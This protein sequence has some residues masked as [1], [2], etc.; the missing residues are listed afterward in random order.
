MPVEFRADLH[1]H[2]CLSPCAELSMTPR[3]IVERA[4]SLGVNVI[5]VCDHNSVENS[6][7]TQYLAKEKGITVVPGIEITSREEVHILGLFGDMKGAEDM[8]AMVYDSLQPGENDEEKFGMQ[9]VANEDDEVMGF[10]R[11]L[12]IGA[13]GLTVNRVVDLI[14]G[15]GGLAVASHI[16][17]EGFGII[18]QLGFIPSDIEF[19]ALEI[20]PRITVAE[21]MKTFS[22]YRHVPWITSSDAHAIEDVGRRTTGLLMYHSTFGE[23][24]LA[25]KGIEGRGVVL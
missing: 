20:S 19:D 8:Q 4:A 9:V 1:I 21:A 10:N 14:H 13:T 24:R 15:F 22:D 5:A 2:T 12:L 3:A 11:R 23:F 25:L 18:G 17:R 6:A 16:D 7:V